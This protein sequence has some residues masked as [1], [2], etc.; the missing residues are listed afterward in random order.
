MCH[1]LRFYLRWAQDR[2]LVPDPPAHTHITKS[3]ATGSQIHTNGQMIICV[4][5]AAYIEPTFSSGSS[6]SWLSR[7][8]WFPLNAK[9]F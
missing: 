4:D 9:Y 6:L 2:P 5:A 8:A 3:N 7:L 1:I